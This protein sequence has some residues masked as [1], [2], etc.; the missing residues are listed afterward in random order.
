MLNSLQNLKK[1][2][3]DSISV[4]REVIG[5]NLIK[6]RKAQ[7]KRDFA[8]VTRLNRVLTILYDEKR[9]LEEL[10]RGLNNYIN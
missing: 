6:L 8:E 5:A 2:Y 9:E 1:E 7:K 3:L 4:Q 10:V